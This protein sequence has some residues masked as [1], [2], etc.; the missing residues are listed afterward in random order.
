MTF[1]N[2]VK[3]FMDL[4]VED[5]ANLL[6][7]PEATVLKWL[8]EG[9]IPSYSI[10]QI[11]RFSRVEIENWMLNQKMH[12]NE[13]TP[14]FESQDTVYSSKGWQQFCLFRAIHKG[15]VLTLDQSF[16][17]ES[18]IQ[19]VMDKAAS[20][21][22]LDADVLTELLLDRE[23]MMPTALNHGVAVPHTRDFLLKSHHDILIVVY[24]NQPMDWGAMDQKPVHTLFFLFACDDKHHLNLLAKLAHLSSDENALAKILQKPEKTDLL[25]YIK[26]W[27]SGV[28]QI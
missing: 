8:D 20:Y 26:D 27:E 23:K 14:V 16:S 15:T 18:V 13:V 6:N 5:V 17:K 7:V 21:L 2:E 22:N 1:S 28:R 25:Q 10:N 4:K 24:L 9:I 3:S 11:P 19:E 12:S